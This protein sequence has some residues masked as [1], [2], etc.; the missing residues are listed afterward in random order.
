MDQYCGKKFQSFDL[1][2]INAGG[3]SFGFSI[4]SFINDPNSTTIPK[5][6]K[7]YRTNFI[8]SF[9]VLKKEMF[10]FCDFTFYYLFINVPN[11]TN[12]LSFRIP[13]IFSVC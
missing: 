12:M 10:R 13:F 8:S 7:I 5:I 9:Y 2:F 4:S 1:P 3:E 6:I 11:S